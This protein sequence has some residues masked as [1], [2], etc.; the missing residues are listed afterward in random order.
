M[1]EQAQTMKYKAVRPSSP[2]SDAPA[3]WYIMLGLEILL[4][5]KYA[6]LLLEENKDLIWLGGKVNRL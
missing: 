6:F 4:G 5:D 3:F 1:A 2:I